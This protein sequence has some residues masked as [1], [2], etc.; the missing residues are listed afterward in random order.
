MASLSHLAQ[1]LAERRQQSALAPL[2]PKAAATP[3]QRSVTS[4]SPANPRPQTR[5]HQRLEELA[6]NWGL[7]A[8]ILFSAAVW[9]LLFVT[10]FDGSHDLRPS[11]GKPA[12]ATTFHQ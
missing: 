5:A 6:V 9:Y 4:T 1:S 2:R 10:V 12:V 7:L 3:A 11:Q 8:G